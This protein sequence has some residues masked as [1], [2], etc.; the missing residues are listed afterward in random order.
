[1]K[2]VLYSNISLDDLQKVAE[3]YFANIPNKNLEAPIY[4]EMPFNEEN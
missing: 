3:E 2:L 4:K 1:M